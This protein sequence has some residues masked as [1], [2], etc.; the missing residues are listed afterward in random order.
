MQRSENAEGNWPP[1]RRIR[2][3]RVARIAA[4][5][6]GENYDRDAGDGTTRGKDGTLSV[7]EAWE[8][9]ADNWI[10]WARTPGHDAYWLYRDAFFELVP[11]AGQA[12]LEIGCGEGRVARD[13]AARG[14]RITG[15]DA[16]PTLVA[17]A[18][19]AHPDGTY[20]VGDAADLPFPAESF[21]LVVAY[22]S[23][24]DIQDMPGALREAA[25]VLA[26]TGRLCVCVTH[27]MAEAGRFAARD[28]NAQFVIEGSYL[29]D[30]HPWYDQQ[31][32]NRGGLQMTFRSYRH[33]L[34]Q[35]T[36]ALER[37]R[38]VIEALREPPV[39]ATEVERDPAEERW[40]RLPCFLMLR[41]TNSQPNNR[42]QT[43]PA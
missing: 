35:Y 4:I 19:Q 40:T 26:P 11:R 20:I 27:P 37:A 39:P 1:D 16:S 32:F 38:L 42:K 25:R 36:R 33:S 5:S 22:N 43:R 13:L 14:H 12:T 21:D 17:A 34:E 2:Q 24:M 3:D 30:Q 6:L 29:N 7:N 8:R 31:T 15:L 41:A 9:E 10:A 23:L 18:R 28:A